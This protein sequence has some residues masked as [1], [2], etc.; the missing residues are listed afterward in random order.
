MAPF[1]AIGL[2]AVLVWGLLACRTPIEDEKLTECFGDEYREYIT[3]SGRFLPRFKS[4]RP[5]PRT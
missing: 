4:C 5:E 2:M 1:L 3:I